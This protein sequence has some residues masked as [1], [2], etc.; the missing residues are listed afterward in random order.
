[1]Q[2][3]H[4]CCADLLTPCHPSMTSSEHF[5]IFN[6]WNWQASFLL[7]P[8]HNVLT[9]QTYEMSFIF[10]SKMIAWNA[11]LSLCFFLL[12]TLYTCW[13]NVN[14]QASL[15]LLINFFVFVFLCFVSESAW[16]TISIDFSFDAV[17]EVYHIAQVLC[18]VFLALSVYHICQCIITPF[19]LPLN[20]TTSH[21]TNML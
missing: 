15:I 9:F 6:V 16:N 5:S 11:V 19:M 7:W 2:L 12:L 3:G 10:F 13:L 1:M 18:I 8:N 17:R 4:L 21:H 14:V 20:L